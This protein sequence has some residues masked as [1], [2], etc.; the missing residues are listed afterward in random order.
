MIET[1]AKNGTLRTDARL[2]SCRRTYGVDVARQSAYLV[3]TLRNSD[4]ADRVLEIAADFEARF[5]SD[6]VIPFLKLLSQSL[7][8]R[9]AI[10]AVPA[11]RKEIERRVT[12]KRR[13][14]YGHA[15]GAEDR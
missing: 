6:D 10:E 11:I 13:K 15:G 1:L 14:R 5:G 7:E 8:S 9:G 4:I 2:E 3:S 12:T